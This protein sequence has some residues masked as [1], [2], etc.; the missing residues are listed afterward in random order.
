MIGNITTPVY[1]IQRRPYF[2]QLFFTQQHISFLA[3][4]SQRIYMRM[5]TENNMIYILPTCLFGLYKRIET[6]RLSVPCCG[7]GNSFPI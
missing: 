4:A 6:L 1:M 3:T 7:I 2:M 5:L